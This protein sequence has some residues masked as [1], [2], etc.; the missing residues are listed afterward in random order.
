MISTKESSEVIRL[1][2][3]GHVDH[4]KSSVIG[5]LMYDLGNINGGETLLTISL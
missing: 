2:V 5:K 1:V 4:G 3:V